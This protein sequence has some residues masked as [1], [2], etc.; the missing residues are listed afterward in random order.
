M[1]T[2][3]QWKV[4]T[5][6]G[7][8]ALASEFAWLCLAP[9]YEEG[10]SLFFTPLLCLVEMAFA[11]CY[12]RRRPWAYRVSPYYA[13]GTGVVMGLFIGQSADFYGAY[14]LPMGSGVE[15]Q[16]WYVA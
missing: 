8:V 6:A 1:T 7:V 9:L 4:Y 15:G 16:A 12:L 11:W 2:R 3:A 14:A 13:L 10:A 5:A